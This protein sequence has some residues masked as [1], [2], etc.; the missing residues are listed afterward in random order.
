MPQLP[1]HVL[2]VSLSPL[3]N[4]CML[5]DEPVIFDICKTAAIRFKFIPYHTN[6]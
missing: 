3:V 1:K 6:E 2:L 4:L 5:S